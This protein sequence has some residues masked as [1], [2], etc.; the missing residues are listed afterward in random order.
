MA[1]RS[2]MLTVMGL[3]AIPMGFALAE[4]DD[5]NAKPANAADCAPS[6]DATCRVWVE[7]HYKHEETRCVLP[8]VVNK[9]WCPEKRETVTIPAVT[10]Q[11][12]VPA[13]T[14]QV[15]CPPVIDRKWIPEERERV[16]IPGRYETKRVDECGCDVQTFIAGH[17][18][19]RICREGRWDERVVQEG[20]YVTNVIT[21]E[22][23]E[24]RIVTPERCESRVVE[25]GH[26]T[27]V[28]AKPERTA[29]TV[30]RTWCP[31]H[32]ETV[33]ASDLNK[34]EGVSMAK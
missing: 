26:W 32:W 9:V 2:L 15:W 10:E 18:E 17:Y 27:E 25:A 19:V 8:A 22:R 30:T 34:P 29:V 23:T 16:W 1:Y 28:T 7:G 13:V 5:Q 31:G 21:P 4:N 24:T 33:Q 11:V 6:A 3:A 20:H 14:E 12:T